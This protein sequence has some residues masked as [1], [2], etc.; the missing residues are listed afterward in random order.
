MLYLQRT[1]VWPSSFLP[2]SLLSPSHQLDSLHFALV[3]PT[4]SYCFYIALRT[5]STSTA[6]P[7]ALPVLPTAS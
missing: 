7:S 1:R 3:S 2:S 5:H 4:T 6:Y